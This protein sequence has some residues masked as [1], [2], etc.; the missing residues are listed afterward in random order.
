M[1]ESVCS[2]AAI[3]QTPHLAKQGWSL[4]RNICNTVARRY[5]LVN[6]SFGAVRSQIS[7]TA[8]PVNAKLNNM[9]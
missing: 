3:R 6:D 8:F 1:G 4:S 9:R 2:K 5:L 7:K